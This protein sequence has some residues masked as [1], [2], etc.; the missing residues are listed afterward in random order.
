HTIRRGVRPMLGE[1]WRSIAPSS[2]RDTD[3]DRGARDHALGLA[4]GRKPWGHC[5]VGGPGEA[6]FR[7]RTEEHRTRL[8]GR[9]RS[10]RSPWKRAAR[11][12]SMSAPGA[13]P[14][15]MRTVT[16]GAELAAAIPDW[17]NSSVRLGARALVLM[18][19]VAL[20]TLPV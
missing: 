13:T 17:R 18:A 12:I 9:H 15:P 7:R 6:P 2:G 4:Y 1:R 10:P 8:V 20:P 16:I 3:C 11:G 5:L 19:I 14:I